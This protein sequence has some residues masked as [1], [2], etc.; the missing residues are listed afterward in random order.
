MA[1]WLFYRSVWGM[2]LF[3]APY[4][5]CVKKVLHSAKGKEKG[6]AAMEFGDA[7]QFCIGGAAGRIFCRKNAWRE[8]EKRTSGIAWGEG[9]YGGRGAL[10]E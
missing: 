2:P 7:M 8:T 3:P 6:T 4:L 5:V 10:D 1:L 9:I